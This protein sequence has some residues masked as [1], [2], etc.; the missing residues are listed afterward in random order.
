L[1]LSLRS[2]S[3]ENGPRS[4]AISTRQLFQI[5]PPK[6]SIWMMED[7]EQDVYVAQLREVFD[8]CDGEGKGFLNKE[9][10]IELCQK[11]QLQDQVPK[12]LAQL[13]GNKENGKVS[14]WNSECVEYIF[15]RHCC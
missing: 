11:L 15:R 1:E 13:L 14:G 4:L 8:S 2:I 5:I 3:L 9:G 6:V 10:L 12:L 7:D